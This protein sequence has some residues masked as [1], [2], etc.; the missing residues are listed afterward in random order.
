MRLSLCK[1]VLDLGTNG[2]GL[3]V[4]W[5]LVNRMGRAEYPSP[6]PRTKLAI[7][8]ETDIDDA[9]REGTLTAQLIDEDGRVLW[10]QDGLFKAAPMG[11]DGFR[12]LLAFD[13]EGYPV[14]PAKGTYRFDVLFEGEV[15]GSERVVFE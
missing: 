13:F 3:P 12:P 9:G 6:F 5:G 1:L 2:D 10:K 14:I 8:V 7:E 4:I 15:L 11:V